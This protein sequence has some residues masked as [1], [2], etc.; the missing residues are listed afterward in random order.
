MMMETEHGKTTS[1]CVGEA[2]QVRIGN[3]WRNGRLEEII[4]EETTNK[5]RIGYSLHTDLTDRVHNVSIDNVRK[6]GEVSN[7][8]WEKQGED[9]DNSSRGSKSRPPSTVRRR[10]TPRDKE[11]EMKAWREKW[12]KNRERYGKD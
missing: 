11:W 9:E 2:I 5:I 12:A 8:E 1:W 4:I 10:T 6:Y 7:E 3:R